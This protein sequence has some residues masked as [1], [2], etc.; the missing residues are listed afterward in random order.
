MD[1]F[2]KIL[3]LFA[4]YLIIFT[5]SC[6]KDEPEQPIIPDDSV[7]SI[8]VLY[9]NDEHG[10]MEANED[11]GGAADLMGLWKSDDGYDGSD[12]FLILSGGDM[13]TGPA[14][15][16]WFQGQSMV[17][18]MNA[19]EYD[20]AALGN[21]EFDFDVD[22][23]EQR[24]SEMDF[25]ILAANVTEKGSGQVPGFI[26]PYIIEEVEGIK[27]GIIGLASRSTPSSAFPVYVEN[28]DFTSY[29]DAIDKY[30]P[31]ARADGAQLLILI[32][33][34][35]YSELDDIVPTAK[36]HGIILIGGGHCHDENAQYYDGMLYIQGG[37]H[38]EAYA[39]VEIQYD[40]RTD[41]ESI[42]TYNVYENF[43]AEPD[44]YVQ[45]IVDTW[46]NDVDQLLSDV[47]AY[48]TPG[49]DRT[50]P[51][52]ANMVTDSWFYT[53]P[54]ADVTL[55]NLGGIRQDIPSGDISLET[56]V[57][58]LPFTNTIVKLELNGDQLLDCI[59]YLLLGG[60]TTIGGTK[61]LDGS[62]I[63]SSEIYSV[64]TTDYLYYKGDTKFSQYDP[65]PE[66]TSVH[67]R[68]PLIE[69]M[70]SLNTS[71]SD[72]LNNYLDYTARR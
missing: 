30:A 14:I 9:T 69:W 15:S 48:C 45:Q 11:K 6:K 68:Q 22:G 17:E 47:I 71:S 8:V 44:E 25:P 54:D 41:E 52:M 31:M 5:S 33:H 16:T 56:I 3:S 38:M 32:G 37:K 19:M 21:H 65:D 23:L 39:K 18:V 63:L 62:P 29:A 20:A 34:V 61:F 4:L 28:F 12:N 26:Q 7:K 57:G 51:Q 58:L 36:E 35:C 67:Y 27:V 42:R 49:I 10:W 66:Y 24:V 64:L 2:L 70:Q 40:L 50:S 59:D 60:M 13:W 46:K 43:G 55:T 1:R 53:F 72:P